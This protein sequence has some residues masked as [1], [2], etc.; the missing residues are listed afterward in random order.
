MGWKEK[1]MRYNFPGIRDELGDGMGYIRENPKG[2]EIVVGVDSGWKLINN[3]NAP[4]KN[5]RLFF[6]TED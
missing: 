5:V 1:R 3:F 2:M 4:V 6:L